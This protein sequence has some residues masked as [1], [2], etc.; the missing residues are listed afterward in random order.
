[1]PGASTPDRTEHITRVL[2]VAQY[3]IKPG[4]PSHP[5]GKSNGYVI[6]VGGQRIYV[7]GVT[8][9]VVEVRAPCD[10]NV[11]LLPMNIPLERMTPAGAAECANALQPKAVYIYHY[12]QSFAAGRGPSPDNE[13][14]LAA[15]RAALAKGIEFR[16]AAWYPLP[17]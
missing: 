2:I 1:M 11:A 17:R 9:C 12:D 3:D 10:I 13:K 8:E 15:F 7:A 14:S 4:E 16:Q 6:S 5:K